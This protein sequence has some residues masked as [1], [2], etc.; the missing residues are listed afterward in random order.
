MKLDWKQVARIAAGVTSEV[1][2]IGAI[3]AAESAAESA[4][5]GSKSGKT[6]DQQVDG[7]ADLAVQVIETAEGFQGKEIVDDAQ[8]QKLVAAVHSSLHDLAAGLLA[9]KAIKAAGPAPTPPAAVT[10]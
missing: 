7:Y 5:S 2:G 1:T 9:A 4:I 6:V 8:V 10:K 3:Q